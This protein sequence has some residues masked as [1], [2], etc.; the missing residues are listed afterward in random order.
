[1]MLV[2]SYLFT[3]LQMHRVSG[4]SRRRS[5]ICVDV[6]DHEFD[7]SWL[8]GKAERLHRVLY[9]LHRD[10]TVA[11]FVEHWECHPQ[12]YTTYDKHCHL[13]WEAP[14]PC[15][16]WPL[17]FIVRSCYVTTPSLVALA[18]WAQAQ[19]S[20]ILKTLKARRHR[21][22]LFWDSG[23]FEPLKSFHWACCVIVL[24]M[25]ALLQHQ[26]MDQKLRPLTILSR[27]A[28]QILSFQ[29]TPLWTDHENFNQIH[30]QHFEI[31]TNQ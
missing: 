16:G 5:T 19:W 14:R 24:N 8:D 3:Y 17:K 1:M 15:L 30:P 21:F 20:R 29:V 22:G 23:R 27:V 6:F 11:I 9:F 31:R 10:T 12:I 7:A 26:A 4:L 2:F 18:T 25:R 28:A 13:I